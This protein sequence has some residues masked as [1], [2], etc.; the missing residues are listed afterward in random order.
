[1]AE[2]LL[3]ARKHKVG[4]STMQRRFDESIGA[5]PEILE[6]SPLFPENP[7]EVENNR[8]TLTFHRPDETGFYPGQV[9]IGDWNLIALPFFAEHDFFEPA[10]SR[11]WKLFAV[12]NNSKLED[13]HFTALFAS[14]KKGQF[15]RVS[16]VVTAG[17]LTPVVWRVLPGY[18]AQPLFAL[19]A[20]RRQVFPDCGRSAD[21]ESSSIAFMSPIQPDGM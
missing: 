19:N 5:P 6:R 20:Q 18:A 17:A 7:V 4:R 9:L 2:E 14:R 15:L 10:F 13:H 16:Q 3:V 12:R 21:A 11:I 1:M 8:S